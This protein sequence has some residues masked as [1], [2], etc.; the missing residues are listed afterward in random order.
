MTD[1]AATCPGSWGRERYLGECDEIRIMHC[2]G[3]SDR[4]VI[5]GYRHA[6]DATPDMTDRDIITAVIAARREAAR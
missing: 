2:S 6:L 4:M 3:C 1:A 5:V